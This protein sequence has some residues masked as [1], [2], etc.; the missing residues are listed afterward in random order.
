VR[1]SLITLLLIAIPCV[2]QTTAAGKAETSGRC[3]PAVT[4]SKNT[5]TIYCGIDKKQGQR[6]LDILNRILA[7]RIDPDAVMAKLDEIKASVEEL[8]KHPP[9]RYASLDESTKEALA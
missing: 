6:M 8:R 2:S 7:N 5:F 9:F 4:G 3:S 1:Y